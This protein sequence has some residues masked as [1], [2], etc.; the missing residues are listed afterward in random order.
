VANGEQVFWN[1]GQCGS[2]H[3][4]RGRGGLPG[5]DLSNIAAERTLQYIRDSLTKPRQPIPAGY[6]PVEVLTKE[7]QR[8]SG[9]AKNDNNFS[10]QLLDRNGR[11]RLFTSDELSSVIYA[12]QSLMPSNYDKSLTAGEVQDLIAFLGRQLIHKVE[13]KR[14]DDEQ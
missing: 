10:I 11:L 3:M 4:I 5:P 13:R 1:K 8:L 6:Q 7:G 14:S 12:K 9:I 2:C